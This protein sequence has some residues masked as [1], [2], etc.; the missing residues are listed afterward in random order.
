MSRREK[1][2]FSFVQ[3]LKLFVRRFFILCD[4][5]KRIY[6]GEGAKETSNCSLNRCFMINTIIFWFGKE[7]YKFKKLALSAE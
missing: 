1:Y 4:V 2:N 5:S 7:K 6:N 3:H